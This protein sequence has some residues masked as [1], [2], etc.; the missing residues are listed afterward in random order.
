MNLQNLPAQQVVL[1]TQELVEL[2]SLHLTPADLSNCVQA[3]RRWNEIFIP[4]LWHTIDDEKLLDETALEA[5]EA[6]RNEIM[7]E[8]R[9]RFQKYGHHIRVL[10]AQW[11]IVI[12]AASFSCTR[13]KSLHLKPSE[14][15]KIDEP[16]TWAAYPE[17]AEAAE[18]ARALV[19][20]NNAREKARRA[21]GSEAYGAAR[22]AGAVTPEEAERLS[23]LFSNEESRTRT[24]SRFEHCF[25]FMGF[26]SNFSVGEPES[27]AAPVAREIKQLPRDLG[28][29]SADRTSVMGCFPRDYTTT[30]L[31]LDWL[32]LQDCWRLI[33]A[34]L[35][36]QKLRIERVPVFR[37]REASRK[38]VHGVLGELKDLK[39]L[40]MP[41]HL[42]DSVDFWS[43]N[44]F[45]PNVESLEV[46]SDCI[47]SI[48]NSDPHQQ[49]LPRNTVRG[50]KTL[51]L[52]LEYQMELFPGVPFF[53]ERLPDLQSFKL[54]CRHVGHR[55][56]ITDTSLEHTLPSQQRQQAIGLKKLHFIG[57]ASHL[58][59]LLPH[60]P[61]LRE[62]EV[63]EMT[64]ETVLALTKHCQKIEV[65][66]QPYD[67]WFIED[68]HAE[69]IPCVGLN[70]LL[71][72]LPTLKTLNTIEKYIHV[73]DLIRM[74][75]AC[76]GLEKFR[77]RIVGLER[78]T[79]SQ[80][81]VYS[82]ISAPGY[83]VDLTEEESAVLQQF[84]RCRE[85][86][87]QVY[88]QLASL[89]KLKV[90]DLG[91]EW[92]YPWTYKSDPSYEVNGKKYLMYE[93]PIPDT[94]EF[95][96]DSGLDRLSALKDLEMFGFEGNNHRIGEK[97][98]EWMVK[99]W[100]RLKLMY[101]LAEDILESIEYDQKKAAL[102]E[103]MQRL[104]PGVVHDSLFVNNI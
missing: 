76:L 1:E 96:L 16:E 103:Y 66:S 51:T 9:T 100:P 88:D 72:H 83:S 48:F 73:D 70:D 31:E 2:L 12:E 33:A 46:R 57:A 56:N 71:I 4:I 87:G 27:K 47:K 101:G 35:G 63:E 36:L 80:E 61:N 43:I 28:I 22:I 13:L 21:A 60:L 86:Q 42:M 78:L 40:Y 92:R 79:E 90:L 41:S 62:I 17:A 18:V 7:D 53:L 10:R 29:L 11:D 74:P 3:N 52:D 25:R 37:E 81:E 6:E 94:M 65:V 68:V 20:T 45:A 84:H 30:R 14:Y 75:W 91:Y 32:L 55:I 97:E 44:E 8:I 58:A 49:D 89:T 50:L 23:S 64:Q 59:S 15:C 67:P 38:Y 85:Q 104:K 54:H 5:L 93:E 26:L 95:S 39:E 82:R 99:R 98:L 77:C 24:L 19:D 69:R 34:N 102:R